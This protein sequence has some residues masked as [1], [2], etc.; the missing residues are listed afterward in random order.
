VNLPGGHQQN[1]TPAMIRSS[2]AFE[3]AKVVVFGGSPEMAVETTQLKMIAPTATM[4]SRRKE[5][6]ND[7]TRPPR[8]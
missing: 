2:P 5:T 1:L 8:W 7:T 3:P 6:E 4:M